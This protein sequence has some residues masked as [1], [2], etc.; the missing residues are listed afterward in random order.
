MYKY[1]YN[2]KVGP[3]NSQVGEHLQ[4]LFMVGKTIDN[5][6]ITGNFRIRKCRYCTTCL[7]IFSY[8]VWRFPYIALD[9]RPYTW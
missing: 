9:N 8:F 6:F 5:G 7:A 3:L 4:K 2:F 1:H